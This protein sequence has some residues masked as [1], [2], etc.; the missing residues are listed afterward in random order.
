MKTLDQVE[1]R[2][3]VDATHT[4][5]DDNSTYI[6]SQ[7]GSYYLTGNLVGESAKTGILIQA[8]FVTL[9][10]NGFQVLGAGGSSLGIAGPSYNYTRISNGTVS[11]WGA[12]GISCGME[13]M[14]DHISSHQNG[15][16]GFSMLQ[17]GIICDC[18]ADSNGLGGLSVGAYSNVSRCTAFGNGGDGISVLQISQIQD[19]IA[20]SNAPGN[21]IVVSFSCRVS[22]S[23]SSNNAAGIYGLGANG[24]GGSIVEGCSVY[25]NGNNGIALSDGCVVL[26]CDCYNNAGPGIAVGGDAKIRDCTIHGNGSVGF[27]GGVIGGSVVEITDCVFQSNAGTGVTLA[28]HC[29]VTRCHVN[30]SS[31]DGI[32]VGSIS[33]VENCSP[34]FQTFGAGIRTSGSQ[35]RIEGNHVTRNLTGILVTG[36]ENLIV[37]NSSSKSSPASTNYSIVAGNRYGQIVDITAG[38]TAAVNGN[39][40]PATTATSDPWANFSY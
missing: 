40:A 15:G 4:P 23:I 1:P 29:H 32:V 7:P 21:G 6:I 25:G 34:D 13:A 10:L 19:C 17:R 5:G 27:P 11:G 30:D 33:V 35:N 37:R 36:T 24:S 3:P 16:H 22:N 31:A 20:S 39:S 18:K 8:D 26:Y 28:D 2:I 38:G 12:T 9:D 14:L